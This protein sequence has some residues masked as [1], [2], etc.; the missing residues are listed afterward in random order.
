MEN[1]V[2]QFE[3]TSL[4]KR[5]SIQIDLEFALIKYTK[6]LFWYLSPSSGVCF[7]FR[8]S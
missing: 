2:Q 7:L 8:W 3:G 4:I 1:Y 5:G 6:Y